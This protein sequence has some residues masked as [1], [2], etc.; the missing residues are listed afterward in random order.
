MPLEA[1]NF[2]EL[3][4]TLQVLHA[5]SCLA[6]FC[7]LCE[8]LTTAPAGLKALQCQQPNRLIGNAPPYWDAA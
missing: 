4:L 8:N 6:A 5:Y 1:D 2:S 3:L 7:L